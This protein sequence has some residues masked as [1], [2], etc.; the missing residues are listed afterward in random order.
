MYSLLIKE[1]KSFFNSLIGYLAIILILLIIGTLMWIFPGT[2]NVMDNGY[3]TM[4]TLF[5]IAPWIFMFLVPAIT[6]RTFADENR[7]GTIE[8]LLTNPINDI[9][10]ILAKYIA[11]VLIV[12]FSLLPTLIYYISVYSLGNPS[13][14][15]DTGGTMGS[16]IGLLLLGASF[17][18]VGIFASSLTNNQIIAFILGMFI[19]FL[20]YI[21]FDFISSLPLFSSIG[22]LI[23]YLGINYHYNSISR[24]V[25]DT[26]DIIYFFSLIGFFLLLTKFILESRKWK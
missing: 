17:T 24:G 3:A 9:Q 23:N 25:I 1:I 8:I 14:N 6:M 15:I 18:A 10:I 4:D 26:R 12:L 13:G 22:N 7:S 21:G 2:L 19:C 11:S 16:Y 5:V 20:V